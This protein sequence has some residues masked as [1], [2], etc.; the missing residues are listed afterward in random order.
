MTDGRKQI[1]KEY[2]LKM[3]QHQS[4]LRVQLSSYTHPDTREKVLYLQMDHFPLDVQNIFEVRQYHGRKYSQEQK[5]KMRA[6][7]SAMR[8]AFEEL[9]GA[10][11]QTIEEM[12][13]APDEAE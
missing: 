1:T 7:L 6:A 12:P 2:I 9:A 5:A 3:F 13:S 4:P 11:E 10:A 8:A